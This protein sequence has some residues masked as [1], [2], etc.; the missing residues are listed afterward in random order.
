MWIRVY[1]CRF[2]CTV[3]FIITTVHLTYCLVIIVIIYTYKV[4][5]IHFQSIEKNINTM[6][7]IVSML[8]YYYKF[9]LYLKD[10]LMIQ[11]QYLVPYFY[12][13]LIPLYE[14]CVLGG[15]CIGYYVER[16]FDDCSN[17]P[18][19]ESSMFYIFQV[20]YLY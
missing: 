2:V 10:L 15:D 5:P 19:E 11:R 20:I 8:Y 14:C 9:E 16:P 18:E 17:Y 6:F 13:D 3:Q 7:I 12:N 1:S 4:I